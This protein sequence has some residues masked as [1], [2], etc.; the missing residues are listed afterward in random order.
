MAR[1]IEEHPARYTVIQGAMCQHGDEN[2]WADRNSNKIN[3]D[4]KPIHMASLSSLPVN[5]SCFVCKPNENRRRLGR[6]SFSP[7]ENLRANWQGAGCLLDK[8]HPTAE[9]HRFKPVQDSRI[10]AKRWPPNPPLRRPIDFIGEKQFVIHLDQ[11][12]S[13]GDPESG[14]IILTFIL[15]VICNSTRRKSPNSTTHTWAHDV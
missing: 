12:A 6:P 14:C 4:I 13:L 8:L 10:E 11:D 1:S 3:F 9:F 15:L 7:P 5:S 2:G